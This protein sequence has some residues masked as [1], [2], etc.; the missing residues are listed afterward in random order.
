VFVCVLTVTRSVTKVVSTRYCVVAAARR[1]VFY[2]DSDARAKELCGSLTSVD[3]RAVYL[4]KTEEQ[5]A[6]QPYGQESAL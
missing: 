1:F 4:Q 6:K 3:M 2:Y 5:M